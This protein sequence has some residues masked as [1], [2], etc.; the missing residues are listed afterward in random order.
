MGGLGVW[1]GGAAVAV[2]GHDGYVA[3]A[4]ES[5]RRDPNAVDET[6]R[7][8]FRFAETL[9]DTDHVLGH[10]IEEPRTVD[11]E[12]LEVR[13]AKDTLGHIS[14]ATLPITIDRTAPS[15]EINESGAPF[16][17]ATVNRPLALLPT[18]RDSSASTLEALL[19]GSPAVPADVDGGLRPGGA[20]GGLVSRRRCEPVE[21][22]RADVAEAP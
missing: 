10:E 15:I 7:Q 12:D 22:Q 16:I 17:G 2:G 11:P 4:Y 5:Y 21:R 8:F 19:D 14:A 3:E 13:E 20:G 6:W 9:G 1:V 18:Y